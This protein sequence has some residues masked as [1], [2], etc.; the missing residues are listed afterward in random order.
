LYP[1]CSDR[2]PLASEQERLDVH[3]GIDAGTAAR[4]EV[5]AVEVE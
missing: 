3:V 2:V 4:R 1:P 5:E